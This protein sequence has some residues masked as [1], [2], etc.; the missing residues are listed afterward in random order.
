MK[1]TEQTPQVDVFSPDA[2][3]LCFRIGTAQQ[4]NANAAI[5]LD[6]AYII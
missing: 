6:T 4:Q 5:D 2:S 1:E 3:T